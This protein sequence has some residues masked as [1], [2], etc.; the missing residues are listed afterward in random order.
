MGSS[1]AHHWS[2]AACGIPS[3]PMKHM[4]KHVFPIMGRITLHMDNCRLVRGPFKKMGLFG[5]NGRNGRNKPK[6]TPIVSSFV[7]TVFFSN[8]TFTEATLLLLQLLL[9]PCFGRHG[10][11]IHVLVLVRK[12]GSSVQVTCNEASCS[13]AT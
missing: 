12:R 5:R 13:L 3:S 9:L 8:G 6:K 11:T 2:H 7:W 10:R 1:H 4:R